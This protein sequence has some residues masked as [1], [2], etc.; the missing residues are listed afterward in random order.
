L[1]AKHYLGPSKSH[2]ECSGAWRWSCTRDHNWRPSEKP[3]QRT[4][5]TWPIVVRW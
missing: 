5:P 4:V 3:I 2:R 1:Q